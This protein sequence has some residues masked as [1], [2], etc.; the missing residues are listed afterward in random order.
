[1]TRRQEKWTAVEIRARVKVQRNLWWT[2]ATFHHQRTETVPQRGR[3][4][5]KLL[6]HKLL[7][8]DT[9]IIT[10]LTSLLCNYVTWVLNYHNPFELFSNFFATAFDKQKQCVKRD[11]VRAP[12]PLPLFAKLASCDLHAVTHSLQK[13]IK[14]ERRNN[15]LFACQ[16][17][18]E[19][20]TNYNVTRE[21]HSQNW[22]VTSL[23]GLSY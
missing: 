6:P 14:G 7:Q 1:M 17:I 19:D 4:R 12:V 18:P 5:I 16:N 3:L 9:K 8:L 21:I 10:L 23:L 20:R 2:D 11:R 15:K 13:L 22:F